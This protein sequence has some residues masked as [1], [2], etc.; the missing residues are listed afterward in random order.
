M[1][2]FY[3]F[4]Q[5]LL[6]RE[7]W[8]YLTIPLIGDSTISPLTMINGTLIQDIEKKD[9]GDIKN[10]GT[11][12]L[13]ISITLKRKHHN[14]TLHWKKQQLGIIHPNYASEIP[15]IL[16][17]SY[18]KSISLPIFFIIHHFNHNIFN[19]IHSSTGGPFIKMCANLEEGRL[20]KKLYEIVWLFACAYL[21]HRQQL[22]LRNW[23]ALKQ[24][25][26]IATIHDV[27]IV[28]TETSGLQW[29]Q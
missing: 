4:H 13:V 28:S 18:L 15:V 19:W 22:F 12:F 21:L 5:S 16:Q 29:V 7:I 9:I 3:D 23:N 24:L 6:R 25:K 20:R 1:I 17:N 2:L 11:L 14:T 8:F 27:R 10:L 26:L